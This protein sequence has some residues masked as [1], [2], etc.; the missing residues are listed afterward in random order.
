M[1][2]ESGTRAL[3]H[4]RPP[5]RMPDANFTEWNSSLSMSRTLGGQ[6]SLSFSLKPSY[7]LLLSTPRARHAF[8][9]LS[10]SPTRQINIEKESS[11][12]R[13]TELSN[14]IVENG[15]AEKEERH[16]L[17]ICA[18][19]IYVPISLIYAKWSV[20]ARSLLG[21]I[22]FQYIF[23]VKCL[24]TNYYRHPP[25]FSTF[26]VRRLARVYSS[27]ASAITFVNR[28]IYH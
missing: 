24:F 14:V 27:I 18:L 8:L 9:S 17:Y 16:F 7:F 10:L 12:S 23:A 25:F 20:R 1:S 2:V 13:N 26:N 11:S 21:F 22:V 4:Y 3:S 5:E 19:V 6:I 15:S 28:R